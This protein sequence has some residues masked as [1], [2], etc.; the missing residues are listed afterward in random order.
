MQYPEG[1]ENFDD[2]GGIG[3]MVCQVP[4][5]GS[6]V[7]PLRSPQAV[8]FLLCKFMNTLS[9]WAR[10]LWR[11]RDGCLSAAAVDKVIA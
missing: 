8:R 2:R 3:I 5:Q 6:R 10:S 9:L 7:R 4:L 11:G 1:T